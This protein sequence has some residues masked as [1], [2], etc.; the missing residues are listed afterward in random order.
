MMQYLEYHFEMVALR[1][2]A[3]E[4]IK[5]GPRIAIVGN[6]NLMPQNIARLLLNYSGKYSMNPI[7]IDADP[8]SSI[9]VDGSI[10]ALEFEYKICED[11][12][13]R[14]DK[15]CLYYGN[16]IPHKKSYFD[17]LKFLIDSITKKIHKGISPF[18]QKSKSTT[19]TAR[20]KNTHFLATE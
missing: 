5:E 14:P 10:G 18:T 8:E 11:L 6:A 1:K 4:K 3:L 2:L 19:P 12:F 17:Q 15:L 9:F 16:R 13:D 20:R 7:Y